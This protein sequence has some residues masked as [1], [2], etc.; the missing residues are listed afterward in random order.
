MVVR[1]LA[2]DDAPPLF[3]LLEKLQTSIF[4]DSEAALR[5]VSVGA[6]V[7]SVAAVLWS[8]RRRGSLADL[9]SAG[10]LTVATTG[11]FHSRQARSYG[12]LLLAGTGLVLSARAL[13]FGQKRAGPLLAVSGATLCL[14]HH[15]GVVLVLTSLVLWPLGT[16]DRP[17]LKVWIGWHLPALLI[18]VLLWSGANTQLRVH[19]ELNVW[20]AHYWQTHSLFLAPLYS[21]GLFL[22]VGL[23]P[24][25]LSVGFASQG[26]TS[27]LF[28][29]LSLVFGAVCLGA[30]APHRTRGERREFLLETGFLLLP[31]LALA[32]ASLM[33]TPVYVLGRTD[34]LAYPAF[35]FLIGRGLA[36]L[37]RKASW[38]FLAFWAA[39]SVLS[40]APSYGVG[41]THL[42]KGIDRRLAASLGQSGLASEDWVIHTFMTAPTIEYYLERLGFSHQTAWYP[43]IAQENTA[44]TYPTPADSSRAYL[45]EANNLFVRMN[46]ALP[47]DAD[48]WIFGSV[49]SITDETVAE[50][51]ESGSVTCEQIGYP[52]SL[53]VYTLVGRAPVRVP[54]LYHQDWVAGDRVVM[55]IPKRSWIPREDLET[56]EIVVKPIR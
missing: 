26:S 47:E 16:S 11:I 1:L 35:V 44:S 34:V 18:W 13:L 14:T 25:E 19:E 7:F 50:V 37:P 43:L 9:W 22:P 32:V 27:P 23:P 2:V 24:S 33:V 3:Y 55:R 52:V 31:L 41:N 21:L 46:D 39:L 53:L 5:A 8:A 51:R 30:A 48:V 10:F 54:F 29:V 4:G 17:S 6:G 56:V 42:A 49:V 20:V 15:V 38:F 12:V 40:L 36:R 45:A 28:T